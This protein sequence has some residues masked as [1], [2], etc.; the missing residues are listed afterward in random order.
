MGLNLTPEANANRQ[1]RLKYKGLSLRGT[2]RPRK[3]IVIGGRR[4]SFFEKIKNMFSGS[5]EN[6]PRIRVNGRR[7]SWDQLQDLHQNR[8]ATLDGSKGRLP[9]WMSFLWVYFFLWAFTWL[10]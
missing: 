4:S 3:M 9:L 8:Q 7:L 10:I 2:H 5:S 1:K 6:T